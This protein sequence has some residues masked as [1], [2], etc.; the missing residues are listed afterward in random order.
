MKTKNLLFAGAIALS[1]I[2]S[3]VASLVNAAPVFA[4][5]VTIEN[6]P[7]INDHTFKAYQIFSGKYEGGALTEIVWGDGINSENFLKAIQSND[8]F[9]I[10]DKNIFAD[11]K[12]AADV[13]NQ[14]K[15]LTTTEQKN[16]FASA[17]EANKT[18]DGESLTVGQP[19]TLDNGY[20]VIVDVTTI[21]PNE[22]NKALNNVLLEIV[23]DEAVNIELK[24]D[25]PTIVKKVKEDDKYAG[26]Y[27]NL[28]N[29]FN[30]VADYSIGEDV[31]FG[32]ESKV[33]DMTHY[34]SYTYKIHD[35]MSKG[36]TLKEN[37]IVVKIGTS[38]L[39]KD[40]DY[41]VKVEH[42]EDGTTSFSI[43]I[44]N[45]KNYAK[46]AVILVTFQAT[47]NSG[48]EVG[49]PGNPNEVYLE[50]SNNPNGTGTGKTETDKVVVFTYELDVT[51]VDK[52]DENKKLGEAEFIL[53]E[54]NTQTSREAKIENGKFA[55]WVAAGQG[56]TLRSGSNG[57][58]TITGLDSG[59]YYLRETKAP[60]G[61]SIPSTLFPVELV[62]ETVHGDSYTGTA[63]DALKSIVVNGEK[64][65]G[66]IETGVGSMTITNTSS[67][68]LPET[69]GMGTTMLYTV[70]AL[71]VGGAA[72]FYVTNKR[73]RKED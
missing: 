7:I 61:Y 11:C 53:Q 25:V 59:T 31:D 38:T 46:D 48:A 42:A 63:T 68:T 10:D 8:L 14:L 17:A 27:G 45:M 13:A 51:K 9:K 36:L 24:T 55:G 73:M 56:T 52:K 33:P 15:N 20:Y 23:G 60:T 12:D 22:T 65:S 49:L 6:S 1:T 44:K 64:D 32:F 58:F 66:V 71:L 69:G 4:A 3:P 40:T 54:D 21:G 30:D 28:G 72:V 43:D 57:L 67:S 50:Y 5:N 19:C 34:T 70:G 37:T 39:T 47:L 2:M 29:K 41:T 62:A 18:G 26:S 35:T 16:A